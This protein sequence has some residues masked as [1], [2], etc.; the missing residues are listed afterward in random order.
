[1]SLSVL[2]VFYGIFPQPAPATASSFRRTGRF[3]CFARPI[4]ERKIV[5]SNYLQSPKLREYLLETRKNIAVVID[6]AAM[7]A[8]KGDTLASVFKSMEILAE[9]PDQ[10]DVRQRHQ[11]SRHDA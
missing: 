9:F 6:Y 11:R 10:V 7:E 1:M 4:T 2:S 5:D 8:L 3:H